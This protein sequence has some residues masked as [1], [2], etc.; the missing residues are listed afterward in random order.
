MESE[1]F[2]AAVNAELKVLRRISKIVHTAAEYFL[3]W[4]DQSSIINGQG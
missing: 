2:A 1:L 4:L 3:E